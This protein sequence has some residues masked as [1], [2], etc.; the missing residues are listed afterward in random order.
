MFTTLR[1]LRHVRRDLLRRFPPSFM[2]NL[3]RL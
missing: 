1:Q 2:I 3:F